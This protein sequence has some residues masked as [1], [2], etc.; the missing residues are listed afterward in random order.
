[1]KSFK[2][3]IFENSKP[4][5][6]GVVLTPKSREL[7]LSH[8][9]ISSRLSKQGLEKIGHH[10]TIKM[11][12]LAGTEHKTGTA[13]T[14]TATHIGHLGDSDNP[15]VVAVRVSGHPSENKTPHI[16][17]GVNREL[18]GKPFHSNK[19]ENWQALSEPIELSGEV[20]EIFK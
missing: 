13:A 9:E 14:L 2:K 5:Y 7:L 11:G 17:L 6:S 15:S 18:G 20:Q 10:M 8:L 4:N 16:T 1:M 19:I 12:G 3:Y